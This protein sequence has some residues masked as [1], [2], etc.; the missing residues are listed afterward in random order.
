[1]LKKRRKKRGSSN[2]LKA[3]R[4]LMTDGRVGAIVPSKCHPRS[5]RSIRMINSFRAKR[6]T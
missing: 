3:A 1:M 5:H 2:T 4:E 6:I